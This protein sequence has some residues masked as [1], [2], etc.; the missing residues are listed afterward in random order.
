MK[1]KVGDVVKVKENLTIGTYGFVPD[2]EQFRGKISR[3][4][5]LNTNSLDEDTLPYKLE[6]SNYNFSDE[7]LEPAEITQDTKELNEWCKK[8]TKE[9]NE[10]C[11]KELKK[12]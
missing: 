11:K 10:W 7:M 12:L 6:F 9:L 8:A 1:Y 2:M 3:I 5:I 4:R